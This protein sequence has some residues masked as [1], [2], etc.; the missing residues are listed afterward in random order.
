VAARQHRWASRYQ[1]LYAYQDANFGYDG[2]Y[3]DQ[4]D[5][6][7][8]FR[9]GFS[10]GFEDGYNNRYQYGR[11][12]GGNYTILGAVLSTVLNLESLR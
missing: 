8:Y 3:V 11:Y 7:Y 10:R 1:D 12:S 2:Y 9:E 5:Y 6:N 4:A